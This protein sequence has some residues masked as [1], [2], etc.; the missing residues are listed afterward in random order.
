MFVWLEKVAI[1]GRVYQL[2][3]KFRGTIPPEMFAVEV[4]AAQGWTLR[5]V[6]ELLLEFEEKWTEPAAESESLVY[7]PGGGAVTEITALQSGDIVAELAQ[8]DSHLLLVTRTGAGKST[9]LKAVLAQ[10]LKSR[11]GAE[12]CILDPKTTDWLGLQRLSGVVTYLPSGESE[13][14][15]LAESCVLRVFEALGRRKEQHQKSL[16][17]G[18]AS[19]KF[20]PLFLVIDEWFSL[21]DRLKRL[22]RLAIQGWLNE[23]VAQ[24]RELNVHAILVSQSHNVEEIGFSRSMRRSFEFCC[25]GATAASFEP[26][27]AAVNDASLFAARADRE[28]LA[29]TLQQAIESAGSRRVC[30]STLGTPKIAILPDLSWVHGIAAAGAGGGVAPETAGSEPLQ[31][32]PA[33]EG[34]CAPGENSVT[35]AGGDGVPADTSGYR[36]LYRAVTKLLECGVSETTVVKEVLGCANGRTFSS[37]GKPALQAL[38]QMGKLEG[39]DK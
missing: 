33:S 32:Q 38:L 29:A 35:G 16:L 20:H 7:A 18:N 10:V 39:W 36:V 30:L 37:K 26:L 4:A 34:G 28:R 3:R 11:K 19:P 17:T 22:R 8:L 6:G 5:V 31:L 15:E 12:L 23:V 1:R 21:F 2:W 24:G 13:S 25:L 27:L 14:V 9:L